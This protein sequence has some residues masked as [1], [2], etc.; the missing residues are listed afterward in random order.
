MNKSI[1]K[2]LV[3]CHYDYAYLLRLEQFKIN[4]MA[5]DFEKA[6]W[7][8]GYEIDVRDMK[9]CVNSHLF[10]RINVKWRFIFHH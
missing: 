8:V 4:A 7:Y 2:Q 6:K 10:R 1:Y 3:T 9:L 5:K